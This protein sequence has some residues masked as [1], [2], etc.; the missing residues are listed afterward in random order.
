M[1]KISLLLIA[2]CVWFDVDAQDLIKSMAGRWQLVAANNGVEV[3]PGIYSAGTDTIYFTATSADDGVSLLC[4]TDNIFDKTGTIYPADWR[5]VLEED[6]AGRHRLGWVLTAA[7]PASDK[8][9]LE[10]RD[11]YL[12]KGFWYF[13]GTEGNHRY[14]YLLGEDAVASAL[15]GM[16]F[17]SQWTTDITSEY[18]LSNEENNARKIYAVVAENIPYDKA[19]GFMEIWSSPK[20]VK[21]SDDAKQGDI[22]NSGEV[23]TT[24]VTVLYNVMFGTDVT[25]D[26]SKCDIDG[27][28]NINTT[29]VTA[30][31]NII[32]GTIR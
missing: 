2:M 6:G 15:I 13:G 12:E 7:Q 10:P 22:D 1:R 5:I 26:P 27:D 9:F 14:I 17:Y 23:N 3:A 24:D 28:G 19:V 8:E 25:I 18:T 29:D 20:L 30:L 11:N 16:T 4:H 21:L 32:F 31:Y